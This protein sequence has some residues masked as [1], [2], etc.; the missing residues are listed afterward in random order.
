[1][2]YIKQKLGQE[3]EQFEKKLIELLNNYAKITQITCYSKQWWNK[4]VAKAR[5]TWAKNKKKLGRNK[6][7]KEEFKQARNWYYRTIRKA[8]RKCWQKFLQGK[9]QFLGAAMD[10]NHYQTAFKYT[11]PL[12]FWITPALRDSNKNM[13]ISIKTKEVLVH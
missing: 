9:S 6:D 7:L 11:K 3:V 5:L 4:E 1:M 13:A 8:K 2:Q 12:Q 10:K